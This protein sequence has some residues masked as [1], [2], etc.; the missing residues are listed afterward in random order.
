MKVLFIQ[1]ACPAYRVAFFTG[2]AER[3]DRLGLLH[4]GTPRF[5]AA[6]S[7]VDEYIGTLRRIG[8]FRYI[9]GLSTYLVGYDLVVVGFDPHWLSSFFLPAVSRRKVVLWSHGMGSRRWMRPLR[10]WLFAR[11]AAM[12]TY[13]ETT[14]RTL[15]RQGLV[16]DK[17]FAAN[18]TLEVP[19]FTD[20]SDQTGDYFLFVGRLQRRKE[21]HLVIEALARLRARGIVRHLRVVGDGEEEAH[22]LRA[23]AARSGVSDLVSFQPGT[24]DADVLYAHFARALAYVSPGHVGLGVLHSFAYGVPVVTLRRRAHAPEYL[25]IRPRENGLLLADDELDA[26]L[27][28]PETAYRRMGAQAYVDYTTGARMAHMVS[29]FAR[30]LAFAHTS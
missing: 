14:R 18:N 9:P 29:S 8:G 1:P 12:V 13:H 2:L 22:H 27:A 20:T 6:D 23:V 16:A 30:A 7:P 5:P 28:L 15:I 25:N 4:F 10:D 17:L 26:G 19:N 24:T 21:L 3:V 11:A